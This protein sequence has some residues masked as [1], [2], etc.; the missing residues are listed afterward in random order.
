M[1]PKRESAILLNLTG[2]YLS[3]TQMFKHKRTNNL[4]TKSDLE[5]K[6]LIATIIPLLSEWMIIFLLEKNSKAQRHQRLGKVPAKT[7]FFLS[8]FYRSKT[9]DASYRETHRW[10]N[11]QWLHN[12]PVC[13]VSSVPLSIYFSSFEFVKCN[14]Y[15]KLKH[16]FST[17][18]LSLFFF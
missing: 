9:V 2:T 6:Q 3:L 16:P 12:A 4:I 10:S 7:I 5:D 17:V 18:P 15:W 8:F 14:D 1:K 11:Y 13:R